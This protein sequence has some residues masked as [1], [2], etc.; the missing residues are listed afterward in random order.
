MKEESK[1]KIEKEEKDSEHEEK[2]ESI[3]EYTTPKVK[4]EENSEHEGPFE[5][6][7]EKMER[8]EIT[9]PILDGEDY[10][11]WKERITMYLKMKKCDVVITR[12]KVAA[13]KDDWEEN[14]LKVET[15]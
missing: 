13:D 11:M 10:S 2:L 14:D 6:K 3:E 4:H 12:A 5:N 8:K 7:E 9:I 1:L 15:T